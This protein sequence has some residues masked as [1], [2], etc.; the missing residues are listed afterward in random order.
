MGEPGGLP[1]MGSHRVRHK[2]SDLAAATFFINSLQEA[3]YLQM[4]NYKLKVWKHLADMHSAGAYL[5]SHLSPGLADAEPSTPSI[6]ARPRLPAFSEDWGSQAVKEAGARDPP[7]WKQSDDVGWANITKEQW[8]P[9][10]L[11]LN[12]G[13]K[14]SWSSDWSWGT[15][16]SGLGVRLGLEDT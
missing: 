15:S 5:S 10:S 6:P 13:R 4:R 1:S 8:M 7:R 3:L 14:S 9:K 12:R 11:S 16:Q 2:W